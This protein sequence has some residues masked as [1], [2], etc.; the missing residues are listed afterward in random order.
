M[1]KIFFLSG[2]QRSGSTLLTCILNQNKDIYSTP[3]SPLFNILLECGKT[4]D[5]CN[6]QFTFNKESTSVN[7]INGI[8]ESYHKDSLKKYVID[9]NRGW[10]HGI[11]ILKQYNIS[12]KVICTIR[13]IPEIISSFI[14]LI[15][16][17][18]NQYNIVDKELRLLNKQI[19]INNRSN[20][21]FERIIDVHRKTIIE[22]LEKNKEHIHI[23][24]YDNL[25]FNTEETLKS[26]YNFLDIPNY[27]HNF[28]Q[29]HN[30]FIEEKDLEWGFE[31]LHYVRN[32]I[33]KESIPPEEVIGKELTEYYSQFNI[34]YS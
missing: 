13:P 19:N 10:I 1:E 20:L 8:I 17:S 26:I 16:N 4:I 30:E 12:P 15:K 31:K 5:N 29:I 6:N 9:K 18:K 23:I 7:V 21:I 34:K 14:T 28:N 33:N 11:D 24:T 32:N 25:V 27:N 22:N 2:L 3:T